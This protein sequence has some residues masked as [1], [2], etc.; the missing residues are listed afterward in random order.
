MWFSYQLLAPDIFFNCV[1]LALCAANYTDPRVADTHRREGMRIVS[2]KDVL[3]VGCDTG[4]QQHL[5]TGPYCTSGPGFFISSSPHRNSSP[6]YAPGT[7]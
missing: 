4:T 2:F 5:L 1:S 3:S 6:D 7:G